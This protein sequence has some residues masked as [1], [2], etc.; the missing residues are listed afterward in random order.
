MAGCQV[1]LE[2]R[3]IVAK[4]NLMPTME[5]LFG[6]ILVGCVSHAAIYRGTHYTIFIF[7]S[8]RPTSL[9]ISDWSLI[10]HA[11]IMNLSI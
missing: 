6:V 2:K 5:V 1:S 9:G 7:T 4:A 10:M 3:V 8:R 11:I